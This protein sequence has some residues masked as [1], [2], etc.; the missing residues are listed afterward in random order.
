MLHFSID[1]QN[2]PD[3]IGIFNLEEIKYDISKHGFFDPLK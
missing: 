3:I 1:E 2:V